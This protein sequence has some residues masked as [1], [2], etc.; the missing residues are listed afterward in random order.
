MPEDTYAKRNKN[1]V[2]ATDYLIATPNDK[3][4]P[5]SGTWVTVRYARRQCKEF[6]LS[7]KM[8]E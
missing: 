5:G 4:R 2:D 1:I 3:E 7:I 8:E 6:I